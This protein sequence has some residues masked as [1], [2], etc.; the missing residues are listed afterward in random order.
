MYSNIPAELRA[1]NQWVNA[2]V[3]LDE[4]GK[5]KKIPINPKTLEFADPTNRAHWGSFEEVVANV[6]KGYAI[7]FCFSEDDPYAVIDLDNKET[8]PATPEQLA[9][10]AKILEAFNSYTETSISG[11]GTHTIIK[12]KIPSGATRDN[13]ELSSQSRYMIMTGNVVNPSP[14]NDYHELVNILY[15]EMK[16]EQANAGISLD[17]SYESDITDAEICERA[18]NA[19]NGE[20]YIQL[21]NGKWEGEYESQSEAD[22]ALLSIIAFYTRDNN[23]V[24]RLFRMT[25]LGKRDKAVRNNTYID[26]A[27]SKVRAQQPPPVDFSELIKNAEMIVPPAPP[28]IP[29]V[30]EVPIDDETPVKLP[31][32]S[33]SIEFPPGLIGEIA[34]YFMST[35]IRPVH[36]ISLAAAISLAAGICGR[37]YNISGTGLN[38]YLVVLARTGSGKEGAL[39]GMES[40][41]SAVRPQIPSV[42]QFLG[43]A[44]FASGQALVKVL[45]ERK[46][47]VSVLGE[48][49]LTLQQISDSRANSAEKMLKKVLLDLYGKSGWN[50]SLQSSVYSDIEKN[51]QVIQAPNVTL[52]GESTP[53]T[54]FEGLDTSHIAEGLIPRFSIIEYTGGRPPRNPNANHPPSQ[55]LKQKFSNFV[56]AAMTLTAANKCCDVPMNPGAQD[57]LDK[58]DLLADRTMNASQMEIEVQLWNR[59]HLKAL[60]LSAL[61]AVG[62]NAGHPMITETVAEYAV[63]FVTRDIQTITSRFTQGYVGQGESRQYADLRTAIEQY[64]ELPLSTIKKYVSTSSN[65]KILRDAKLVP[66]QYLVK[67]LSAVASFRNDKMG[68]NFALKRCLQAVVEQGELIEINRVTMKEQHEYSGVAYG[69][70]RNW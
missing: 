57:I 36:E 30:P 9:R 38:Q 48:F 5:R 11:R 67:K 54:F 4:K 66:Y 3:S 50:R 69:I 46:C 17:D 65:P 63:R 39:S 44:A 61:L 35:A 45:N 26:F 58:F 40:L 19:L 60:K 22:F 1:L 20:K 10:H 33:S 52:L 31:M 68:A 16:Q 51:T 64:F 55:E 47:F 41:I 49:G 43:P 28:S 23:Q 70:G 15:N 14:I 13:V 34:S 12:G 7:G 2:D 59:A 24:R 18:S 56:A 53:E 42:S 27:L 32:S 62:I 6:S 8:N 29:E 37:S 21:C 25:A